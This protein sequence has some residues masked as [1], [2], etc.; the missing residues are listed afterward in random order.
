MAIGLLG[1]ARAKVNLRNFCLKGESIMFDAINLVEI[2]RD[3]F[4]F[5]SNR[6]NPKQIVGDAGI[7]VK[8]MTTLVPQSY[9]PDQCFASITLTAK[10]FAKLVQ[11]QQ[12]HIITEANEWDM[13]MPLIGQ[14]VPSSARRKNIIN[15]W[16]NSKSVPDGK[17]ETLLVYLFNSEI[18]K[19][20]IHLDKKNSLFVV[21]DGAGRTSAFMEELNRVQK[22]DLSLS[23]H[24]AI[25]R[26]LL[27]QLNLNFSGDKSRG[28]QDFL[29]YNYYIKRTSNATNMLVEAHRLDI[30]GDE[31][32]SF[33]DPRWATWVVKKVNE[34]YG[35]KKGS[36][37]DFLPWKFEG[38]QRNYD[39]G[40]AGSISS[41][42]TVLRGHGSDSLLKQ[43]KLAGLEIKDLPEFICFAFREWYVMSSSAVKEIVSGS[44]E[45]RT[46]TNQPIAPR[47]KTSL[48]L[49][50]M[51]LLSTIVYNDSG[52]DSRKFREGIE[53]LFNR[54]FKLF[55]DM[56]YIEVGKKKK[57]SAD[58]FWFY[59]RWFCTAQ[60]NSGAQNTQKCLKEFINCYQSV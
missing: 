9:M 39:Y 23:D 40:K 35:D 37:L 15:G 21:F 24:I 28:L 44:Y 59:N 10:E 32:D 33:D 20:G 30:D 46:E 36:I 54:H 12:F 56:G 22:E 45:H 11:N 55:K 14:R 29:L 41:L 5:Q 3:D 60:F 50:L 16:N 47:V 17:V 52:Y 13:I 38:K 57:M 26:N 6:G 19:N 4:R 8:D 31:P 49:R 18:N 53:D 42:H 1:L 58:D 51:L 2:G 48:G 25:K 43:I 34:L 7:F 27:F